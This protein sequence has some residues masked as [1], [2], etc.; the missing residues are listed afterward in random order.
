[1]GG[2]LNL[3][4][5]W[6]PLLMS[7]QR[8][9]WEEEQKALEER[10][11]IDQMMKE[12]AEERAIQEL[13]DMQEAAGGKKRMNRV[14]WMYSGPSSGQNGTTE[15]MEGYLLGKRRVDN[16]I[17]N[18]ETK[19]LEKNAGQESFMEA[20][21]SA[22][23]PRDNLAKAS[24][25]PMAAVRQQEQ[26]ALETMMNDPGDHQRE[27]AST[28][29]IV[30]GTKKAGIA[31]N[32]IGEMTMTR[33]DTATAHAT[34]A[35]LVRGHDRGLL[36]GGAV[37]TRDVSVDAMK[38]IIASG[39]PTSAV[40][41]SV[42]DPVLLTRT[43]GVMSVVIQRSNSPK[44]T[45]D[46]AEE[47]ARKLAAMQSSASSLE[48]DRKKRLAA[49]EAREEEER[50]ADDKRRSEKGR[51]VAG[52]HRQAE[53]NIGLGERLKRSRAGLEKLEAY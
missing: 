46:D 12:R 44:P 47:R 33:D 42:R 22:S 31:A 14:D 27:T 21:P 16:L 36:T 15:E 25:D 7:N 6:H 2:D 40:T 37:M 24:M 5:S 18:D 8:R 34:I 45:K 29:N 28:G 30:T 1:M 32:V 38:S 35:T 10:K 23:N 50:L 49:L 52:L 9:V 13:Q 19:K 53:N 17:K 26:A 43:A 20:Q 11:R 51:F 3:K 4:K 39:T 48:E 41:L